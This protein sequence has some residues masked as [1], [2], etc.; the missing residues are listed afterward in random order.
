MNEDEADGLFGWVHPDLNI[1]AAYK[2]LSK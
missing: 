1:P 2:D